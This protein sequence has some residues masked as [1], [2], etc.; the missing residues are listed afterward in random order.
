MENL[1]DGIE[2][3]LLMGPGPSCVPAGVYSALSRK[4]LG[5]LDPYFLKIMDGLKEMLQQVMN[6]KN[7]L[8]IPVSGTGS[9]GMEACFVN[10]VEPCSGRG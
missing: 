3:V 2:E 10:L 6:T 1:L 4:T 5:H 8:T 7:K 9:A